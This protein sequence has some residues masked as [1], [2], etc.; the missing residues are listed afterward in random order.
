MIGCRQ[1]LVSVGEDGEARI[2]ALEVEDDLLAVTEKRQPVTLQLL[3]RVCVSLNLGLR[4]K[5]ISQLRLD[6]DTTTIQLRRRKIDV[7]IICSRRSRIV[8]LS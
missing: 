5:P 8:V 2:W 7:F 4:T 3:F 6:Y 1:R